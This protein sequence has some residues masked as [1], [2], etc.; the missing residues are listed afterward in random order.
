MSNRLA[1]KKITALA[2][3]SGI[4]E[5]AFQEYKDKVVEK[6]GER[7]ETDI[8]DE[9]AQDRVSSHPVSNREV[10]LAGTG[11]VLFYD[12]LTGRYFQSTVEEVRRAENVI[13]HELNHHMAASLSDFCNEVGLPPTEY[14]DTHGW[15][16]DVQIEVQMSAVLSTDNRPCIAIGFNKLPVLEYARLWQ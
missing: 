4:S 9:I 16:P 14:T 6:L 8:R 11:E 15:G 12:M 13:N 2:I 1:S 3:A 10:I 7:K 5:R